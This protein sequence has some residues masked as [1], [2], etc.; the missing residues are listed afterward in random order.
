MMPETIRHV[1]DGEE[2]VVSSQV[3]P[4]DPRARERA[5]LGP[6]PLSVHYLGFQDVEGRREYALRARRGDREGHYV[7]SIDLG[8]FAKRQA[9][10]Q[11]G[12]QICYEMLLHELANSELRAAGDIVVTPGDLAAYKENHSVPARSRSPRPRPAESLKA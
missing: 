1:S 5:A 3:P 9:L 8:A 12:P 6:K 4:P 11:D 2:L 7:L 10:L